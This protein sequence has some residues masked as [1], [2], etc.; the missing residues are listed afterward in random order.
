MAFDPV[1]AKSS[2]LGELFCNSIFWWTL[3][4]T[5]LQ[6]AYD[7]RLRASRVPQDLPNQELDYYYSL[8]MQVFL[9]SALSTTGLSRTYRHNYRNNYRLPLMQR[10]SVTVSP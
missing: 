10:K 4:P 5:H 7:T 3:S 6:C 9:N 1:H 8:T 2:F